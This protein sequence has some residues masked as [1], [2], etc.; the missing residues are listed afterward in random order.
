[1]ARHAC[2]LH[3]VRPRPEPDGFL[4]LEPSELPRATGRQP[5]RRRVVGLPGGGRAAL[6]NS[7]GEHCPPAN[8]L[9]SQAVDIAHDTH[10]CTVHA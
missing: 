1:M 7:A 2:E 4:R 9:M 5:Q 6:N 10:D 3:A 8:V